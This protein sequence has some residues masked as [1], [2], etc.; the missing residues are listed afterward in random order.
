MRSSFIC[1]D[2][3][4]LLSGVETGKITTWPLTNYRYDCELEDRFDSVGLSQSRNWR[5][6]FQKG[7]PAF[8]KQFE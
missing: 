2:N 6:R 3:A 7:N 5:S 4:D 1:T 8:K